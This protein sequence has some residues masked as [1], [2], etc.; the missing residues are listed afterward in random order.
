[1]A[2]RLLIWLAYVCAIDELNVGVCGHD[3]LEDALLREEGVG[4]V[5]HDAGIVVAFIHILIVG[6]LVESPN[7]DH[8][9]TASLGKIY[10]VIRLLAPRTLAG[11]QV[12][13]LVGV[14]GFHRVLFPGLLEMDIR[15]LGHDGRQDAPLYG[16]GVG[17]VVHDAGG[18]VAFTYI[19][20]VGVLVEGVRV[21]CEKNY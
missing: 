6:V 12:I 19:L 13:D 14:G 1:M 10:L 20:P 4:A 15:I 16:E 3:G 7:A 17:A 5:V 11:V 18:V 2:Y 21:P 9:T 8:C